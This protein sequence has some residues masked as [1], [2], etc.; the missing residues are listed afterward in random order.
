MAKPRDAAETSGSAGARAKREALK[1]EAKE[2]RDLAKEATKALLQEKVTDATRK[3]AAGIVERTEQHPEPP[4]WRGRKE[5]AQRAPISRDAII[6]AA[7]RILDAEGVAALTVRRLAHDLDT[8]PATLYWHIAGKDELGELVYDRI[9]AA[10]ELPE[11][12]PSQ[13]AAQLKAMATQSY[14][15]LLQ[16]NDAVKLSIGRVPTGPSMM[17][18]MEW[19]L[20]LLRGTGMPDEVACY[21]GDLLGRYIDASV[22]DDHGTAPGGKGPEH[23]EMMSM[24]VDY[25]GS[26]PESRYPNLVSMVRSG[27]MFSMDNERR[28]EMGMD[29]ILRGVSSYLDEPR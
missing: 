23:D 28:F 3:V 2:A 10:V 5:K 12:D 13:W 8:G 16:H 22:L 15:L 11:P 9:M 18:I 20:A 4:W 14:R 24:V 26:L 1:S 19:L 6:D 29:I 25:F 7:I 21:F 27:A 17:R